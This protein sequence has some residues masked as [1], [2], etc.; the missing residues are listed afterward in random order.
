MICYMCEEKIDEEDTANHG[1]RFL[2]NDAP[3]KE[4]C[5]GCYMEFIK[6]KMNEIL[7]IFNPK[8]TTTKEK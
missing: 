1:S 5:E 7:L 8:R 6:K 2:R 4:V 3:V